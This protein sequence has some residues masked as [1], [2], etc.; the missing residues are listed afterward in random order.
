MLIN[1][2]LILL[3]IAV[4]FLHCQYGIYCVC[5]PNHS[6]RIDTLFTFA[7]TFSFILTWMTNKTPLYLLKVG[8][9][10]TRWFDACCLVVNPSCCLHSCFYIFTRLVT[11]NSLKP[12]I[13]IDFVCRFTSD[14][15]GWRN[16]DAI[17]KMLLLQDLTGSP[18]MKK[19][20]KNEKNLLYFF[21]AVMDPGSLWCCNTRLHSPAVSVETK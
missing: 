18:L 2:E 17:V 21:F 6:I 8:V 20:I 14:L 15:M 9:W 13:N 7:F 11:T 19:K 12:N 16:P 3:Y 4:P 10:L 5:K 1:I